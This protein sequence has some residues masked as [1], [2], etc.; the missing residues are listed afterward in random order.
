[1]VEDSSSFWSDIQRYQDMLAA[2]PSS[3]CF[4][5]LSQL[6]R[7]LGLLDDAIS[8][9]KKGCQLHPE[10]HGGFF[11]LGSAYY[12][13]GLV[14]RARQAL[15]TCL[16]LEPDD[17]QAQK[18]LGQLYVEAGEIPLAKKV[19][20][21]LLQQNPD[22][23]ESELLLRSLPSISADAESE[24]AAWDESE[25]ILELTDVVEDLTDLE[26]LSEVEELPSL[27]ESEE[28]E[29][30]WAM[31]PPVE[32]SPATK[33]SA[34]NPLATAT[35]AELYASQGF[36]DK[37]LA[38]YRDL[39]LADPDNLSYLARTAALA[40]LR[41]QTQEAPRPVPPASLEGKPASQD[42]LSVPQTDLENGLNSWLE[43]IRRRRDGV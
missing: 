30:F 5:P 36:T 22:D 29:E 39:L 8:V 13:Q 35:L 14:S 23:R 15:E 37:A 12:D 17:F 38:V 9:A 31:E 3:L 21:Q 43:N 34:R 10:F 4:A 1:M 41:E 25:D 2:D 40:E 11:A 28:L 27:E 18:L 26:E 7:K 24:E 16:S 19:L 42:E 6:Y 33:G 32:P 20:E